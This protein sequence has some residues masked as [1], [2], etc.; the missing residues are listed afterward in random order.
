[1]A[2]TDKVFGQG[3]KFVL[4]S[5]TVA[6]LTNIS[7]PGFSSDDIDVTTHNSSNYA[8][9]FIKGLT[10]AGEI[11]IEGMFNYTDYVT[12]YN[13]QWTQSLYSASIVVPTTPSQ[14]KW[15]ANVY[16]KGLEGGVP[17]DDKIDF[18]ATCKITGKPSLT[19]I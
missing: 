1:M 13:G 15:L 6:E 10:D 19:Q 5:T 8:R 16:V 7:L 2:N 18:S 3:A 11:T 9:E 17:H 12:M 14:T 4:G